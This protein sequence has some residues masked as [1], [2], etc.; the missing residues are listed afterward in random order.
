[1]R[2]DRRFTKSALGP[3]T[4]C[5][6][7]QPACGRRVGSSGAMDTGSAAVACAREYFRAAR[8]LIPIQRGESRRGV[9]YPTPRRA[10]SQLIE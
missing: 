8:D 6:C 5:A 2:D 10:V 1:M 9:A 4:T 7:I 3:R